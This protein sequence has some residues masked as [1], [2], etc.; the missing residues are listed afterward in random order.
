M[1]SLR[2]RL[3][4]LV[5]DRLP[6]LAWCATIRRSRATVEVVHGSEVFAS[7]TMIAEGAWSGSFSEQGFV[8]A[9]QLV[10]S[11]LVAGERLICRSSSHTL[12][13]LWCVRTPT[14]VF[15]SNSLPLVLATSKLPLLLSSVH[16][17]ADLLSFIDGIRGLRARVVTHRSG[18]LTQMVC[19]RFLINHHL[20]FSPVKVG[21]NH[22]SP[23]GDFSDYI[24]ASIS[25]SQSICSNARAPERGFA[26]QPLATVSRGYDSPACAVIARSCGATDAITFASARAGYADDNDDGTEIAQRL[27]L[28]VTRYSRSAYLEGDGSAEVASL[29]SGGGGED[30][31]LAP[32]AGML[33][34]RVLFTGFLGDT[35]WS[36]VGEPRFS[37]RFRILYPGGGSLGEFRLRSG[38]IHLPLPTLFLRHH[39]EILRI[40][41]SAEMQQ[42]RLGTDYDRPIPRRIAEQAGVPRDAFGRTKMA[43]TAPMYYDGADD[44]LGRRARAEFERFADE[45]ADE[46]AQALGRYRRI[47]SIAQVTHRIK[48]SLFARSS[49]HHGIARFSARLSPRLSDRYRRFPSPR[50]FLVH[51][52][53]RQ[54]AT[55]Y[56]RVLAEL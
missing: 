56:E 33:H 46:I 12:E 53:V 20:E 38:F 54:L 35:L 27:G 52:A 22:P 23:I 8:D 44:T 45:N 34:R 5:S 11:G 26:Y 24:Q 9:E 30:V 32:A 48:A 25:T 37:E 3:A 16:L 36:L 10:G 1:G 6:A 7:E 43:I 42:W 17:E 31:V 2:V 41:R 18:E 51:W 47:Y 28:Q 55:Q 49:S 4:P 21:R 39:Q 29:A 40:S 13:R 50:L 19:A 14:E 15:L